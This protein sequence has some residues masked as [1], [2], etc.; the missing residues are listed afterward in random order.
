[1][2]SNRMCPH[3]G[4]P[5]APVE[6]T[7]LVPFREDAPTVETVIPETVCTD[8]PAISQEPGR[9][10]HPFELG[11]GAPATPMDQEPR[12]T[13]NLFRRASWEIGDDGS[14]EFDPLAVPI[15]DPFLPYA[16]SD[17]PGPAAS[18]ID[19]SGRPD[20]P[21]SFDSL[22]SG[23]PHSS[24]SSDPLAVVLAPPDRRAPQPPIS[25]P[26]ESGEP[27]PRSWTLLL[28]G[29]YAS[30]V[31]M[32]L[33]YLIWINPR[34]P[35]PFRP[36]LPP[37]VRLDRSVARANPA[38]IPEDMLTTIGRPLTIGSLEVTPLSIVKGLVELER[39]D[40]DG[41]VELS[42]GGEALRLAVRFRNL[43]R[44]QAYAPLDPA[45]L[46]QSDSGQ[47]ESFIE[48]GGAPIE[49]YPLALASEMAI[50]GQ[51][52][53]AIAPG[54]TAE[55]VV[56]SDREPMNRLLPPLV[57]RLKLRVGPDQTALIGVR[58]SLR[59]VR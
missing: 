15:P 48:T 44:D 41:E 23:R 32:A 59:E 16:E 33:A 9:S 46:R 37:A 52:F 13:R 8:A 31:T 35:R 58:F 14:A 45:F 53:E 11:G 34:S 24:G 4:N 49:L 56:V 1:M 54:Q 42:D 30:A 20:S 2:T 51:A 50:V 18:V 40:Q 26:F 22:D 36:T 28:L 19:S 27:E 10:K 29:S 43:S 39:T 3:C 5:I 12:E 17:E 7:E 47:T 6:G 38:L 21:V 55:S 57:W 25:Q